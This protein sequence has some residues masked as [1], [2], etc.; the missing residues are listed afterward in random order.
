LPAPC[1]ALAEVVK[2]VPD[3][4]VGDEE[5]KQ[6]AVA[7]PWQRPEKRC[8]VGVRTLVVEDVQGVLA[9]RRVGDGVCLGSPVTDFL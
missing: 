4:L 8:S 3:K 9:D 5:A 1:G 7:F 6:L 2:E